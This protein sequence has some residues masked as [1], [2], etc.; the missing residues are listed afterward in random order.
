MTPVWRTHP[1]AVCATLVRSRGC[2]S[3]VGG[4]RH[5]A[6]RMQQPH[7]APAFI[8]SERRGLL[9]LQSAHWRTHTHEINTQRKRMKNADAYEHSHTL[10]TSL[11]SFRL[12]R[13]RRRRYVLRFGVRRFLNYLQTESVSDDLKGSKW[14]MMRTDRNH[15]WETFT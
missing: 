4:G 9:L 1:T 10:C 13:N 3:A 11:L 14:W 12:D 8:L 7:P 15:L 5:L 6:A 2:V